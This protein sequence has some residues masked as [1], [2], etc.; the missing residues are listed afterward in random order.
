MLGLWRALEEVQSRFRVVPMVDDAERIIETILR[1]AMASDDAR[2]YVAE[3]TGRL[4][5]MAVA[6]LDEP[7]R[8]GLS[9]IRGVELSRVVVAADARGRGIGRLLAGAAAGFARERGATHLIAKTFA[10]NEDARAFWRRAGFT[11][12]VETLVR[13]VG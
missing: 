6:E 9:R 4:L 11:P 2:V 13:P 1:D 10:G 7:H 3:E 12:R 5:G 8:T